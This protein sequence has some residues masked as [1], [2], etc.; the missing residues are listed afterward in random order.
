MA[1]LN[2]DARTVA[3]DTGAADAIPAGWYDAMIDASE[4]KPTKD[5]SGAFVEL[6]FNVLSGQYVGRKVFSRLNI[7]N[8]NPVAQEIGFKQL[9]AVCHAVGVLTVGESSELHGKPCKI[10][11]K[12]R[13]ASGDYEASNEISAYK[14]VNDPS[15]ASTAPA[16]I[17]APAGL[18]AGFAPPPQAQPFQMAPGQAPMQQFQQPAPQQQMQPAPQQFQQ[19]APQQFVQQ[20]QP[21]QQPAPTQMQPMQPA[22]QQA[23]PQG[24]Q[25]P[26]ADQPWA[27]APAAPVQ[28]YQQPQQQ[29]QVMQPQ[30]QQPQQQMQPVNP[31]V[32]QFAQATPPWGPQ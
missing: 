25:Q 29:P 1:T 18:P 13:A 16:G 14:N 26:S 11:V 2:F 12:L 28:Q 7:R 17:G 23:A 24:W 5:G 20:G 9:S 6:R 15:A 21:M 19:P 22:Q 31:A 32:Q 27:Q 3:P 10:K 4:I 8:G 30:Q